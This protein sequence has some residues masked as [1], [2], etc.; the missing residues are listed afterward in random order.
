MTTVAPAVPNG[1]ANATVEDDVSLCGGGSDK[2]NIQMQ[3][4]LLKAFNDI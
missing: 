3:L 4:Q 2:D 1:G